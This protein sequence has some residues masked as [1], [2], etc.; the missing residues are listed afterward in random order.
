MSKACG[1]NLPHQQ[2]CY[3]CHREK[4]P[5]ENGLPLFDKLRWIKALVTLRFCSLARLRIE[6]MKKR[7]QQKNA[8]LKIYF[9]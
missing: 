3:L 9:L 8:W 4:K 5:A 2:T 1:P 7:S 6:K